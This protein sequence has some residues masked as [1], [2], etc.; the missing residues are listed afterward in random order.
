MPGVVSWSA[1]FTLSP[2]TP[3]VPGIISPGRPDGYRL[4]DKFVAT[5]LSGR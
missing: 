3:L 2:K 4:D 5:A 1:L